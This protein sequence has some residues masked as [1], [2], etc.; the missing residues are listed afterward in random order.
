MNRSAHCKASCTTAGSA[1]LQ[2]S[3]PRRTVL[4]VQLKNRIV[5]QP[6]PH[7]W[8]KHA[9]KHR[10]KPLR[11]PEVQHPTQPMPR[12]NA[13][14]VAGVSGANTSGNTV[15]CLGRAISC[16][17]AVAP[18]NGLTWL[19]QMPHRSF[20]TGLRRAHRLRTWSARQAPGS[21]PAVALVTQAP[22]SV[23]GRRC[24]ARQSAA[25]A[26]LLSTRKARVWQGSAQWPAERRRSPGQRI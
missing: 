6:W 7:G 8:P 5:P 1:A 10:R 2:M 13:T 11:G 18:G 23:V 16:F 24:L 15:T 4:L 17:A 21:A 22:A 20:S 3:C 25:V 26:S 14:T 9:A 12:L 19:R